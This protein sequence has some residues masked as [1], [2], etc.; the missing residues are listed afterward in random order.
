MLIIW[1]KMVPLPSRKLLP[2]P[3][4]RLPLERVGG[5]TPGLNWRSRCNS[6]RLARPGWTRGRENFD[7]RFQNIFP[8][9]RLNSETLNTR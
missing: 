5:G 9:T 6:D 3:V 1:L 2:G 4:I 8:D 7:N